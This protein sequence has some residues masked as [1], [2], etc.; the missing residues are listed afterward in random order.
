V[1]KDHA[2]APMGRPWYGVFLFL[3]VLLTIGFGLYLRHALRGPMTIMLN[4]QVQMPYEY[5]RE[6]DDLPEITVEATL[7]GVTAKYTGVALKDLIDR[8]QPSSDAQLI[9][10][11]ASDGYAFFIS[12]E[13]LRQNASLL[14]TTDSEAEEAS[15]NIVGPEN[16]KAWVRGVSEIIAV[17]STSLEI[18]GKVERPEVYRPG[19]WQYEMDGANLDL[20]SGPRKVQGAPLS[21]VL[22]AMHPLPEA[23]TVLVNGVEGQISLPLSEVLADEEIR[24]FTVIDTDGLSFAIARMNGTILQKQAKG[25]VVR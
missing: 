24:I 14:L 15:F 16:S 9:L 17:G 1:V 22:E 21:K 3:A 4:G 8:A 25:I 7:R 12:M 23:S 13:E 11:Q 10:I 2:P 5:P 18:A 20:G 19:D 6:N